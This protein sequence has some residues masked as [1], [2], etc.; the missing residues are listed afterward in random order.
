MLDTRMSRTITHHS[1]SRSTCRPSIGVSSCI[2]SRALGWGGGGREQTRGE[3]G[4]S[5]RGD[6]QTLARERASQVGTH[7]SGSRLRLTSS[8]ACR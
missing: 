7:P 5:T 6:A 1:S 4:V 2:S 8:M 3:H